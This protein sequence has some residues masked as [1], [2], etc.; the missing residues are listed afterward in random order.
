MSVRCINRDHPNNNFRVI[1]TFKCL[2]CVKELNCPIN[3]LQRKLWYYSMH[4]MGPIVEPIS[5][6]NAVDIRVLVMTI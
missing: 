5:E 2:E 4:E 1:G 3:L 6:F